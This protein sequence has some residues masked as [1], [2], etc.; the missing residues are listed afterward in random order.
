MCGR[1]SLRRYDLVRAVFDATP[2]FPEFDERPRFNIAPTQTVPII[3]TDSSDRRVIAL[4]QWGLIPSWT[5][6]KPTRLPINARAET[7][8]KRPMFRDA[9]EHRRCLIPVDGF[10]EWKG[11]KPPK[12]P[13][14]FHMK[15]DR[16]FALAGVWERGRPEP[17]AEPID[18]FTII[19]TP[20]NEL[21]AP[22][23]NR[24]PAILAPKDYARWLDQE[25]SAGT[26]M[27][28]LH[29]YAGEE[30]E[31]T[32]I[33]RKVNDVRNEGPDVLEPKEETDRQSPPTLF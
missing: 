14:F 2:T 22:I 13:Y 21:A 6:G 18:T 32:A 19:T 3:R 31:A 1:V 4:A 11:A 12:Q 26:A 25:N 9:M 17:D 23:H 15:D 28:L 24:M 33:G 10:Y 30:M 8:T 29:P 7:V 27:G 20:P 16:L 5:K